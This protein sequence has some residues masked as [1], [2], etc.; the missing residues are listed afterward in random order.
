MST[1]EKYFFFLGELWVCLVKILVLY[2]EKLCLKFFLY[3]I[4]CCYQGLFVPMLSLV[5][6]GSKLVALVL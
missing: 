5:T 3:N 2:V 4:L 1:N 6:N